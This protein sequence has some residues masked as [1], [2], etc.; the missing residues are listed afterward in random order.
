MRDV[1]KAGET[2]ECA[3]GAFCRVDPDSVELFADCVLG[4]EPGFACARTA[5]EDECLVIGEAVFY[6]LKGVVTTDE[7]IAD[8]RRAALPGCAGGGVIALVASIGTTYFA[9]WLNNQRRAESIRVVVCAEVGAMKDRAKRYIGG[10]A[11]AASSSVP[12]L[13]T[14]ADDLGFLTGEQAVAY[15]MTVTLAMEF[16]ENPTDERA[17]ALLKACDRAQEALGCLPHGQ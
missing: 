16:K 10:D 11:Q 14:V 2:G 3:C 8:G 4:S 6:L 9:A 15:R 5:G 7:I 13:T 1:E 17:D 12:M